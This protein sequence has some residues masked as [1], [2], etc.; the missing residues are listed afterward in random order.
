[1]EGKE[2]KQKIDTELSG[3]VFTDSMMKKVLGNPKR[4][5]SHS[6][7]RYVAIIALTFLIGGTTAFAG[8]YFLNKVNVNETILPE[9]DEM[10]IVEM[11]PLNAEID[12]Y[13]QMHKD[14][15]DYAALQS[16]LGI[17]LLES[18]YATDQSYLQGS[19]ET[20]R[21]D[22]AIIK[23]E[24]YII[25]DTRHYTYLEN[26]NRYQYEHGD[27]YYSPISLSMDLI[28]SQE[29][30]DQGW[31]TDYLGFYEYVESY[32]SKQGYRVNLV[33]DTTEENE[34]EDY[35]SEK[36]AIFVADGIRYTIC[37]RTSMKVIK[38][39]VDSME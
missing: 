15:S 23:I 1:M 21:K 27:T 18:R 25:G 2:I 31:D 10:Q 6:M 8:Y 13:G 28:L 22:Y 12:K 38:E 24:N 11:K 5:I 9:L 32:T 29:Q 39:I 17:D 4:Q 30:L 34:S 37:G 3:M 33:W 35:I 16:N 19:I 14:F 7:L 26:E 20:D 36:C